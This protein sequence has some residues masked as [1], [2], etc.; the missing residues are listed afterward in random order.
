ML[1]CSPIILY[2]Y[3]QIAPESAAEFCDATEMDEMLT[4]RVM[5]LTDE[6]KNEMRLADDH[7]RNLLQRTEQS[8][9][10]QLMRTHGTIRSLR[11]VSGEAMIEWDKDW[12]SD[13]WNKNVGI[14]TLRKLRNQ[15]PRRSRASPSSESW[16]A[17]EIASASGRRKAPTLWTWR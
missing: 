15:N 12:N 8:A 17:P 13:G 6:E 9:R 4:L 3:P 10:E 11:P 1:L 7:F 14:T 16:F 5:T 2:D